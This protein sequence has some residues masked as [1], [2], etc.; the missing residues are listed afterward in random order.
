MNKIDK[1]S[2]HQQQYI[3]TIY[4]LCQEEGHAHSKDI[5]TSL[6]IRMPSVTEALRMLSSME[7]IN[8][9]ARQAVT[10]T[11]LGTQ[12]GKELHKRHAVF[13]SF[14]TDILGFDNDYAEK[15][16]CKIEHVIDDELRKRLNSFS[17]FLKNDI[18][19]DGKNPVL[20]FKKKYSLD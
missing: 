16:A 12:I 19:I 6:E 3:E 9:K 2:L 15:Y 10:L 18:S 20:M 8:Y 4:G 1:L 5:A 7:L 17:K 11:D 14:F 13:A